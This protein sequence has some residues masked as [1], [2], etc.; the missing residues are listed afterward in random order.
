MPEIEI[1]IEY[2]VPC[3]FLPRAEEVEHALLESLGRRVGSLRLKPGRGGV[4]QVRVGGELIYDKN[5]DS[6]DVP[7]IVRRAEK[8]VGAGGE[9]IAIPQRRG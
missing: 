2:C 5:A 1:E 6:F 3:G 4:F 7:E 8:L 9:A